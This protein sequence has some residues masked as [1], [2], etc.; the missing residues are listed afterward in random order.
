[1]SKR[2][3]G[4]LSYLFLAIVVV[5]AA[6][7][8]TLAPSY[9]ECARNY[10][11]RESQ[12]ET[13]GSND[14]SIGG[15][16]RN[17]LVIVECE[18]EFFRRNEATLTAVAVIFIAFFTL[19]L[20]RSTARLWKAGER[21]IGVVEKAAE[22]AKLS[23]QAAVDS[24]RAHLFVSIKASNLDRP[25]QNARLDDGPEPSVATPVDPPCIDYVLSNYGRTVALLKEVKHA[26]TWES[27]EGLRSYQPGTHGPLE[28]IAPQTES[29]V[30]SC[31]F[32]GDFTSRDTRAI[33]TGKRA[34]LLF[35]QAI[36]VDAFN[37][38]RGVRWQCRC[39]GGNFDLVSYQE[40]EPERQDRG[41][42]PD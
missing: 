25:L 40:Y 4:L 13:P 27:T 41:P 37:H 23:A 21:Q 10:E 2:L 16:P 33:V 42:A 24:E 32:R 20:Q 36:F 11:T 22:T 26:I 18:G 6:A 9:R 34:L 1:M 3:M 8:A 19:A 5:V 35:G 30:I 29:K 14:K 7:A 31:R 17:V 15:I 12:T 39:A 28:V 38:T